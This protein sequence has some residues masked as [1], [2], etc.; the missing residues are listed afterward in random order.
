MTIR[1]LFQFVEAVEILHS[2]AMMGVSNIHDPTHIGD[3]QGV[4]IYR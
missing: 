3:A 2:K 4:E 1:T